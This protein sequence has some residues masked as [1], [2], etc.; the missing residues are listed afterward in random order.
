MYTDTKSSYDFVTAPTQTVES[1]ELSALYRK[2]RIQ[3]DRL[4]SW[5]LGWSDPSESPDIDESLSKAGLIDV[6]GSVMS[7][8]KDILAEAEPLWQSSKRADDRSRTSEK[9][10]D[11]KL[12]LVTWDR[13]RFED[14]IRDLTSSIDTLYDLSRMRQIN[15][16]SPS[17][18]KTST[19]TS[20]QSKLTSEETRQFESTRMKT[21]QQID[22]ACLLTDPRDPK[23]TIEYSSLA[24]TFPVG[25]AGSRQIVYLSRLHSSGNPWK[26]E[27]RPPIVPVLLEYA[28]YDP[29]YANTGIPPSMTRFE[30]LFAGLQ[31]S[32]DARPDF[33]V[34]NLVGYFEDSTQAHFGLLYELPT[35]F[36]SMGGTPGNVTLPYSA[37]LSDLL[38]SDIF[39]P[40]LEVK[41]RLATNIATTVFDLHSKGIVHGNIAASNVVF[42]E[43]Q[44]PGT[45]DAD[46][47]SAINTRQAF[48]QS[49]ELFPGEA[50]SRQ[51]GDDIYGAE[52]ILYRHSLDPRVTSKTILK[53]ESRSLDVYALA[54][55]LLEIALWQPIRDIFPPH[56]GLP[57][58]TTELYRQI[59]ARCGSKYLS[60]VKACWRSIDDEMSNRIRP[61]VPLQKV[62]GRVVKA[63]ESCCVL[64]DG[65]EEEDIQE[66]EFSNSSTLL[67]R[68][69]TKVP[70]PSSFNYSA[71]FSNMDERQRTMDVLSNVFKARDERYRQKGFS[72]SPETQKPSPSKSAAGITPP[73][74]MPV[75]SKPIL[76][77]RE[78]KDVTNMIE[79]TGNDPCAHHLY[80][81]ETDFI[82]VIPAVLP[83]PQIIPSKPKVRVFLSVKVSQEHLDYWHTAL[84]P[85]IN[86]ALRGFYRKY[87]ESVEISLESV[88]ET[89]QRT[90]PT[91]LVVCTSVGKVRGILKNK[92]EYDSE[93]YG[94]LVCRG[95]ILRSRKQPTK[96]SMANP[97]QIITKPANHHYQKQP[98]NGASIGAFVDGRHLP[99]V[100]FG[101]LIMID[102]KPFGLTVHHMLDDP[103]A[104]AEDVIDTQSPAPTRSSDNTVHQIAALHQLSELTLQDFDEPIEEDDEYGYAI[105]ETGSDTYSE[106]SLESDYMSDEEDDQLKEPGDIEGIPQGCGDGYA[107]TQPALD[108]VEE[109]FYGE[110]EDRDEDHLDTFK[111][112]EVY[113][114]SGI[115][116]RTEQ[117]ITHEIDWAVFEFQDDRLPVSNQWKDGDK[118]CKTKSP[119]PVKI[120]PWSKLHDLEVH[121]MART[122][123]LQTGRILP[124]MSIVKIFGRQT[125]SQ[126]YQVSGR[127]GIPG[128]SG[129]WLIDNQEGR[130]CGH[131]LAWSSRKKVAYICPM[132]I[133][134]SDIAETLGAKTVCFPNAAVVQ[135]EAPVPATARVE[136]DEDEAHLSSN[137]QRSVPSASDDNPRTPTP[138]QLHNEPRIEDQLFRSQT[139]LMTSRYSIENDERMIDA[140]DSMRVRTSSP[141]VTSHG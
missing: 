74:R 22:P 84:M 29:I 13:A 66:V 2:L 112:G 86:Q 91:I 116:R 24:G 120:A 127:L 17:L 1:P 58:D 132:E 11:S 9:T 44:S 12:V 33:G 100:S 34:L 101:G 7:T 52:N 105:S 81:T 111:L 62:Y 117:G 73:A 97:D 138:F 8:I 99:P 76:P 14:L 42:F 140:L 78:K 18:K 90:K 25:L 64:D 45:K 60:A 51:S 95:R 85:R 87:P 83:T 121:C 69:R 40:A 130:A 68:Q 26:L 15:R 123:G 126:S 3:K 27:G 21:P 113:A 125:P 55:L 4:V 80:E 56:K 133:L 129:A 96:R 43:Q 79:S 103:E 23:S 59:A 16:S 5:G 77:P 75:D 71:Q 88:G 136:V 20:F 54:M 124:G 102:D 48:L 108:D 106:A 19:T 53:H 128:D 36:R 63:L 37:S 72:P 92:F 131:V 35:R 6:V 70:E 134:L 38:V 110:E 137:D 107:V 46:A 31:T 82:P 93:T 141:S 32:L 135:M 114:S 94:L 104:V 28:A 10:G 41:Y 61:E 98:L 118:H 115:R 49:F 50:P 67:G 47:L 139:P 89:A 65:P 122:T 57:S 39:E 119:Y 109:S 30:K